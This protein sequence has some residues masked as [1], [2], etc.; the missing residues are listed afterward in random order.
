LTVKDEAG[1]VTQTPAVEPLFIDF[2][3]PTARIVD[4]EAKAENPPRN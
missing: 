1:N 3:R 2:V 4:V